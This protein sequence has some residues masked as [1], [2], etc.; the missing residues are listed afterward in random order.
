MS[1][2]VWFV[3]INVFLVLVLFSSVGLAQHTQEVPGVSLTDP[4]ELV[5]Q[6][7]KLPKGMRVTLKQETYQAFSFKEYMELLEMDSDLREAD[8]EVKLLTTQTE[9]LEKAVVELDSALKEADAMMQACDAEV[10]RIDLKVHEDTE[11][12]L[13]DTTKLRRR[14]RIGWSIAGATAG[15]LL[16]TILTSLVPQ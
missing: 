11:Q 15:A 1:T 5:Y 4:D 2:S 13:K 7:Y 10:D 12:Y 6:I 3:K 9:E 16:I 14:S 8:H